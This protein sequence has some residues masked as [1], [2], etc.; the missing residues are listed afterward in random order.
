MFERK[1][2]SNR[3]HHITS[4]LGNAEMG[5]EGY[6]SPGRMPPGQVLKSITD[7]AYQVPVPF[8]GIIWTSVMPETKVFAHKQRR[9]APPPNVIWTVILKVFEIRSSLSISFV[10]YNNADPL[11]F[12]AITKVTG[13]TLHR[14]ITKPVLSNVCSRG[15]YSPRSWDLTHHW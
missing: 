2:D 14:F 10:S 4:L 11:V 1:A 12:D 5:A 9:F 3:S 6:Q 15:R 13:T 8:P 7:S